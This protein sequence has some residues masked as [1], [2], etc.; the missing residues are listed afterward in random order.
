[1]IARVLKGGLIGLVFIGYPFIIYLLLTHNLP[2]LTVVLVFGLIFWK[3]QHRDDR[4]WWALALLA[5]ALAVSLVSGPA[6]ISKLSPVLIH[7]SLFTLFWTSLKTRPLIEQFARLDFP[8]IPPVIADYCRNLTKVW[9]LF[10]AA[11]V[12]GCLW[13]A[14]WGSDSLW[15]LYNGL[16]VYFLIGALMVGEYIWRRIRFPWLEI[17][18]LM[19]T[20][21]N[22]SKNGHKIWG[23]KRDERIE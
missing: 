13:L 23:Q 12:A 5:V 8:E 4:L 16:I 1:M 14:F 18:S 21:K 11:N 3:I 10:F 22:I 15:T 9:A 20:A 2:W 17:P 6:A 7:V 19:Q